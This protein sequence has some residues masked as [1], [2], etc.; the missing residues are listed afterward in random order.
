MLFCK[1]F[2]LQ[3]LVCFSLIFSL[4]SD[5]FEGCGAPLVMLYGLR[6]AKRSLMSWGGKIAH[7]CSIQI[8]NFTSSNYEGP[9]SPTKILIKMRTSSLDNAILIFTINALGFLYK[10]VINTLVSLRELWTSS[11]TITRLPRFLQIF[12]DCPFLFTYFK[13]LVNRSRRAAGLQWFHSI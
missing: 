3:V 5:K 12:R 9:R 1:C 2:Q 6:F 10:H 7:P 13:V 8:V 11:P 4:Y